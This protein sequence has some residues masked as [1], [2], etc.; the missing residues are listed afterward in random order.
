MVV[1]KAMVAAEKVMVV[2]EKVSGAV[3]KAREA[4]VRAREAAAMATAAVAMVVAVTVAVTVAAVMVRCHNEARCQNRAFYTWWWPGRRCRSCGL[5]WQLLRYTTHC[6]RRGRPSR[7]HSTTLEPSASAH[8]VGL[9][10][11]H[12]CRSRE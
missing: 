4:G 9:A 1:V 7:A 10:F 3:E 11:H 2:E 8:R 6:N 12:K 5:K